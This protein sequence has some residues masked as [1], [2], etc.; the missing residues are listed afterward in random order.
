MSLEQTRV[1]LV[2][3]GWYWVDP[4][5]GVPMDAINVYC[6]MTAKGETC[7]YPETE[8]RLVSG[9]LR[10]RMTDSVFIYQYLDLV[11]IKSC[12]NSSEFMP[13]GSC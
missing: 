11:L 1:F 13:V 9:Y 2:I 10:R 6:N 3:I 4:N 5:L 8:S 7:V 12:R